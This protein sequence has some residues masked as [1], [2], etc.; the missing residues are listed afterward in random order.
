[1]TTLYTL[2]TLPTELANKTICAFCE[3]YT[4]AYCCFNCSEYKGLMSVAE[5]MTTYSVTE[6]SN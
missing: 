2:D 1:M 4:D 3:T 5:F 6:W